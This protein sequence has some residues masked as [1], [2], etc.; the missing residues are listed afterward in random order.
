MLAKARYR[1][2]SL[3]SF[4]DVFSAWLATVPPTGWEGTSA[5]LE[6]A[7]EDLNAERKLR[8]LIPRCS[9]LARIFHHICSEWNGAVAEGLV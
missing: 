3:Q 5:E 4:R 1:E 7:L 9:G 2:A 6:S 8:G